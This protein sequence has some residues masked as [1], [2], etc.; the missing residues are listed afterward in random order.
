MGNVE[1]HRAAHDAFNRR[2][3]DEAARPMREDAIYT[4]H[5]RNHSVKGPLEFTDWMQGWM[6]AMSDA[7]ISDPHY[8]DGGDYTVCM[9]HGQGTNDGQMGPLQATGRRMDLP[10]CEVLRYD[11]QGKITAGEIFYDA[12]TMMVQFGLAEP[13][14][15]G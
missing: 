6:T 15:M 7:R 1:T 3:F 13:M 2:A 12:A 8:I 14:P 11:A 10:M 5:P 9:F 4:D